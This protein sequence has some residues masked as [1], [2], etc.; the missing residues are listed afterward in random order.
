MSQLRTPLTRQGVTIGF[1]TR[2]S[3]RHVLDRHTKINSFEWHKKSIFTIPTHLINSLIEATNDVGN[4]STDATYGRMEVKLH[5]AFPQG[6][7][8]EGEDAHVMVCCFEQNGQFLKLK[9]VYPE[10]CSGCEFS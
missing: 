6:L 3:I 5:T 10:K 9:T 2:A 7:A 8:M 1:A 4:I